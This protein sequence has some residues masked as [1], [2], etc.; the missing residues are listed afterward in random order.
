MIV[1]I[2]GPPGSG[3]TT[4]AELYARTYGPV[5]IS[6]G[7]IFREMAAERGMDLVAFSTYAEKHHDVDRRLDEMIL[8]AVKKN[9]L[10]GRDVVVDGRIQAHLLARES[11]RAFSVLVTAPL[12]I[13][14]KRVADREGKSERHALEEILA[15]ERS[16]RERYREIYEID[17]EDV[18]V[19][20]LELDSTELRPEAIV[21]RIHEGAVAWAKP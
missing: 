17:L 2:G 13:R 14:A 15:R 4:A 1:A 20:D 9:A 19:Y 12:D 7:K 21:R 8:T 18:S 6:G 16:E 11:V 3:K 5:L 10:E